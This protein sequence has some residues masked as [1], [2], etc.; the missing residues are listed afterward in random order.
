MV[1][2]FL[3]LKI[4]LWTILVLFLLL[5][6]LLCILLF[7]PIR[8]KA[9]GFKYKDDY[10]LSAAITWFLNAVNV[11]AV[12]SSEKIQADYRLL[13]IKKN[14]LKV[15]RKQENTADNTVKKEENAEKKAKEIVSERPSEEFLDK[16]FANL[17]EGI[18]EKPKEDETL[19]EN[20]EIKES[21]SD[22]KETTS[23]PT[24]QKTNTKK[25]NKEAKNKGKAKK[26]E[27]KD[28]KS[29]DFDTAKENILNKISSFINKLKK[30]KEN[31]SNKIYDIKA[32]DNSFGIKS[33]IVATFSLIKKIFIKIKP[34]KFKLHLDIGRGDAYD[35]GTLSGILA[36]IQPY[37]GEDVVIS[38]DFEEKKLEGEFDIKGSFNLF[39]L[40]FPVVVAALTKPFFPVIKYI[41]K[42]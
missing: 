13:M 11:T 34:R 41:L 14:I 21:P 1:I 28:K 42:K 31:L 3:I 10:S 9:D 22:T 6:T 2:F 29:F 27:K 40:A 20:I 32:F 25:E 17:E 33:L 30:F 16:D 24:V 37:L 7:V 39:S 19:Y 36:V 35:D 4:L 18:K 5:I 15:Q 26:E 12:F 23:V 8:Y 38:P